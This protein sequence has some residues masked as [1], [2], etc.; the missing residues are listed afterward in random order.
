[1]KFF[2]YIIGITSLFLL[3]LGIPT[4]VIPNPYFTRMT[5][6]YWFDYFY[7]IADSLLLG[8]YFGLVISKK[9]TRRSDG[10]IASGGLAGFFGI[11]CPICNKLL[12]WLFGAT[13]L[14]QYFE[15]IRP[16]VGLLSV[17]I[18]LWAIRSVRQ[19]AYCHIEKN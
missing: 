15:P 14:L 11:A 3:V 2:L 4:A 17:I 1:M 10:K 9:L 19:P 6:I 18:L 7:L 12:L 8:I 5:P 13:W 16:F